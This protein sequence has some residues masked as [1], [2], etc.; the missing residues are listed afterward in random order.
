VWKS[1]RAWCAKCRIALGSRSSTTF[2]VSIWA[3][4]SVDVVIAD[5][6]MEHLIDPMATPITIRALLRPGGTL[7]SE[8]C[9]RRSLLAKVMKAK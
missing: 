6:V 5:Q 8:T 4:A 7:L 3:E 1:P 9:D 2:L